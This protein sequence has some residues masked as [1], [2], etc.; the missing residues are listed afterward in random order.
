MAERAARAST[1]AAGIR[2]GMAAPGLKRAEPEVRMNAGGWV[3]GAVEV[4][5]GF[6]AVKRDRCVIH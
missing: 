6:V 4:R 2:R 5:A 3:G 1:A